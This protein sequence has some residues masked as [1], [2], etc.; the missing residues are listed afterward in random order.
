MMAVHDIWLKNNVAP[1]DDGLRRRRTRKIALEIESNNVLHTSLIN[2]LQP[3][4]PSP[5]YIFL[6]FPSNA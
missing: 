5:P 6:V 4:P 2:I 1:P 3:V